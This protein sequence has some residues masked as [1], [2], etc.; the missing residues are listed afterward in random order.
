MINDYAIEKGI[1]HEIANEMIDRAKRNQ[2]ILEEKI[3]QYTLANKRDKESVDELKRFAE[4]L[5][6][7][8]NQILM[9]FSRA[10]WDVEKE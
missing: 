8:K 6:L 1:N 9:A 3:K 5:G 4:E 7:Q 10:R 2:K